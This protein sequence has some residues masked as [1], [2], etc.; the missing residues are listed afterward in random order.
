MS[1]QGLIL[2]VNNT[3]FT[4]KWVQGFAG[5]DGGQDLLVVELVVELRRGGCGV[6]GSLGGGRGDVGFDLSL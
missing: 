6:G 4:F 2:A 1:V 3:G 5:A